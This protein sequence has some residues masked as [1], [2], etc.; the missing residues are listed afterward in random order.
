MGICPATLDDSFDGINSGIN[1][2]RICWAVAGTLCEGKKQGVFTSKRES[3]V[4]CDFFKIVGRQESARESPTKLLKFLAD[5]TDASFLGELTYKWVKAGERFLVQGVIEDTAYIIEK[6]TC[7]T[8]V[9]KNGCLYPADHYS[10]NILDQALGSILDKPETG[11]IMLEP[12]DI[13]ILSTDGFHNLVLP[14]QIV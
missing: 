6:G 12:G 14:E 11:S 5:T 1:A 8:V 3:C 2:G 13:L 9:E 10:R 7:L 4:K